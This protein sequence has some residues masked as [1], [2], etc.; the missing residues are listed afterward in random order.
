MSEKLR[1][2]QFVCIFH[3]PLKRSVVKMY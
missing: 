2:T 3:N 1:V